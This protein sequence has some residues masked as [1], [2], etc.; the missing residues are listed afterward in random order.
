M[1]R[2]RLLGEG[3]GEKK[4]IDHL[5]SNEP[6]PVSLASSIEDPIVID[7]I[8]AVPIGDAGNQRNGRQ[9]FITDVFVRGYIE[10]PSSILSI[11]QKGG[12][13][14]IVLLLDKQSNGAQPAG[15]AVFILPS[16]RL[17]IFGYRNLDNQERFEVLDSTI[18]QVVP[19]AAVVTGGDSA[20]ARVVY[21]FSL[22]K[23]GVNITVNHSGDPGTL[24]EVVDN[25]IHM[26]IWT[27]DTLGSVLRYG[28]S[29][30]CRFWD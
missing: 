24:A 25:S 30:R 8:S 10:L 3:K 14:K 22:Q 15:N 1:K 9:I 26:M 6:V 29:A 13:V 23:K 7:C 28:Y 16:N 17:E 12:L 2:T 4:Y 11:P 21:N 18:V 27:M 19:A 5:V 20:W